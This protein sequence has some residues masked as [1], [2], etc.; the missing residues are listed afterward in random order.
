MYKVHSEHKEQI[1]WGKFRTGKRALKNILMPYNEK[2]WLAR[3]WNSQGAHE[4]FTRGSNNPMQWF[5]N[6]DTSN[7]S[8]SM[9]PVKVIC[10][11][12]GPLKISNI[13][14]P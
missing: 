8:M 13:S 1:H 5:T 2:P 11:T 7:F 4:C 9:S 12:C 3:K 14:I 6:S 10:K